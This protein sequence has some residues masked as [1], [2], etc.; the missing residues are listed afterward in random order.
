MKSVLLGFCFLDEWDVVVMCCDMA[1]VLTPTPYFF[2]LFKTDQ[3][4]TT[5][6]KQEKLDSSGA[7]MRARSGLVKLS[8]RTFQ[9]HVSRIKKQ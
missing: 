7:H 3:T 9:T 6:G 2:D 8:A 1:A 4:L 5:Q